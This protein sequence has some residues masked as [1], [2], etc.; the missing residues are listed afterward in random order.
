MSSEGIGSKVVCQVAF[1]VKDIEASARAFADV[2]GLPVP[3]P[4]ETGVPAETNTVYR[5]R[6]TEGRAKLAFFNMGQVS[7]ELIEPIGGPSTWAEHLEAH[8]EG[9]H[10]IAFHVEGMDHVLAYLEGKG[11]PTVQRGDYPGGRYG[12]VDGASKLHCVLE[13]LEDMPTG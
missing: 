2:F 4:T 12:Y 9:I 10:H 6:P 3:E 1:V 8:G 13:L 7:L 11:L 5:G